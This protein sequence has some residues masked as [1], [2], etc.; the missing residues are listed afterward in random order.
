MQ[1]TYYVTI[2]QSTETLGGL[3]AT[4]EEIPYLTAGATIKSN[5]TGATTT[6]TAVITSTTFYVEDS[7]GFIEETTAIVKS[8]M[9]T[10]ESLSTLL[11]TVLVNDN[12]KSILNIFA[13][14]FQSEYTA[15]LD[16]PTTQNVDKCPSNI[17]QHLAA[18]YGLSFDPD[19]DEDTKCELIRLSQYI[20][21][22]RGTK[23]SIVAI[24]NALG[25]SA[26]VQELFTKPY[27]NIIDTITGD[28][29]SIEVTG[30]QLPVAGQFKLKDQMTTSTKMSWI[31]IIDSPYQFQL[32]TGE[33]ARYS[34]GDSIR[35]FD[36]STERDATNFPITSSYI[37]V[38]YTDRKSPIR[39]LTASVL[40]II[41][42]YL[43]D[44]KSS[45][46]RLWGGT[47]IERILLSLVSFK[48]DGELID[49]GPT[50]TTEP[51]Y[52]STQTLKEFEG[53]I[54]TAKLDD[55]LIN[56]LDNNIVLDEVDWLSVETTTNL[57]QVDL[58]NIEL[59]SVNDT[60]TVTKR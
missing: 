8:A 4:Y 31:R 26:K 3:I 57:N 33:G 30:V 25:Y 32:D 24:F 16:I 58:T 2:K 44:T 10:G 35:I 51:P 42:K 5:R 55:G 22:K 59:L 15:I 28:T 19:L 36:Y 48:K 29:I 20:Y 21:L 14:E 12:M 41:N 54:P 39:D 56:E 11:P 34:E 53:V 38:V 6:V 17:L 23:D 40:R 18:A 52:F 60:W 1:T 13:S 37:N 43:N 27:E 7:A 50:I 47:G 46:A 45:H 49:E 9:F